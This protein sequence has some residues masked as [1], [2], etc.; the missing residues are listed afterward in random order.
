MELF[1]TVKDAANKNRSELA[2]AAGII[3][4]AGA[5]L[6]CRSR[7]LKAEDILEK[8]RKVE[9]VTDV[10]DPEKRTETDVTTKTDILLAY[11]ETYWPVLLLFG[12]GTF[13][14]IGSH[15]DML[16]KLSNALTIYSITNK[17]KKDYE[18]A[19]KSVLSPKK[20]EEIRHAV[21]A[22]DISANPVESA[23]IIETGHG[24]SLFRDAAS[25]R[26]F[27]AN[28]E[29]VDSC[30]T[31]FNDTLNDMATTGDGCLDLNDWYDMLGLPIIDLGRL[32]TFSQATGLMR[33]DYNWVPVDDDRNCT[34]IYYS[35][36]NFA[37]G[38]DFMDY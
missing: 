9:V 24:H 36:M 33:I 15:K 29:W 27:Y 13:F 25:G 7:T 31:A 22:N 16:N 17:A 11:A 20:E 18:E 26:Y 21:A 14:C 6:V 10:N 37:G 3:S 5:V 38:R 32:W 8:H 12:I 35:P 4:Y 30:K 34:V 2:L 19:A 28:K 23:V 1:N